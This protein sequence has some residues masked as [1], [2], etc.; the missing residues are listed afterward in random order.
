MKAQVIEQFERDYLN[1]LLLAHDGNVTR[2]AQ[3]AG[4]D[5]RVL[6]QLIRKHKIEL[7]EFRRT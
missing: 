2:A 5:R 1:G 3:A 4:K 6:R 7:R